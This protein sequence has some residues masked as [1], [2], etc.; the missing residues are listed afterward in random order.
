MTEEAIH[1]RKAV[2]ARREAL[3]AAR[4]EALEELRGSIE[5]KRQNVVDE[6]VKD[7]QEGA[8]EGCEFFS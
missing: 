8:D 7:R 5:R 4:A 6:F 1:M 2:P 3:L